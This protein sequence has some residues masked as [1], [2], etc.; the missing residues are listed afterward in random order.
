MKYKRED[1]L[2]LNEENVKQLFKFC[3]ATKETE[4][5]DILSCSF[6][7]NGTSLKIPDISFKRKSLITKAH[8]IIYM[9]GQL[10]KVHKRSIDMFLQDGFKKYDGTN[11][12]SDKGLLFS[13]YY[14]GCAASVLPDFEQSIVRKNIICPLLNMPNLKPTLSP[15]D[16]NFNKWCR[17]NDIVK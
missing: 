12:T 10:E 7:E 3:M 17:E 8:S 4:T 5:S 13:L 2:D 1:M 16:P 11:W 14:I 6:I 9:L 15:N